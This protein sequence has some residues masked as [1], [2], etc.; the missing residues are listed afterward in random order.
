MN[1]P[2]RFHPSSVLGVLLMLCASASFADVSE[3]KKAC[4]DIQAKAASSAIAEA[5]K[6]LNKAINT[7]KSPSSGDAARQIKWF[8]ALDSTTAAQVRAKYEAALGNVAFVQVWCPVSNDLTFKWDSGDL[9]AVHPSAPGAIFLPPDF[10]NLGT[11]GAD[12]QMGTIIHE[13]THLSG[14]GLHPEVYGVTK[15]KALA[16][17]K[18]T[19][20]RNNSD[21]YQYYAED[22]VFTLP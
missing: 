11:S 13:A 3:H 16:A 6:A 17:Q 19:Q 8:G 15:A 22:T 12:S 21:N 20:A 4:T 9:A 7:L 1:K 18:P 10:F 14:V 5:K 2:Q